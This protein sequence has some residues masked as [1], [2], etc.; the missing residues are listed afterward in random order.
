MISKCRYACLYLVLGLIVLVGCNGSDEPKPFRSHWNPFYW[1]ECLSTA[2]HQTTTY[3]KAVLELA[4]RSGDADYWRLVELVLAAG[5]KPDHFLLIE[6]LPYGGPDTYWFILLV[7]VRGDWFLYTGQTPPFGTVDIG[8][9]YYITNE[10]KFI[11]FSG[12]KLERR[13]PVERLLNCMEKSEA[14]DSE[15]QVIGPGW[16]GYV[17]DGDAMAIHIYRKAD[18]KKAD[19]ILVSPIVSPEIIVQGKL[20]LDALKNF[21][22]T[23]VGMREKIL[24]PDSLEKKDFKIER[25]YF[26]KTLSP[27]VVL[28]GLMFLLYEQHK[29]GSIRDISLPKNPFWDGETEKPDAEEKKSGGESGSPPVNRLK[30]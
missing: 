3:E 21:A 20:T 14:W 26:D 11:C 16:D 28:N 2:L 25:E 5:D 4:G 1:E 10:D 27:R 7:E 18:N 9:K 15:S 19:F 23:R 8:P 30:K 22:L 29:S 12:R 24:G 13:G 17:V 6:Q